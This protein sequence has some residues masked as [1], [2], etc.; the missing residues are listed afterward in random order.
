MQNNQNPLVSIV[1]PV[2]NGA[3]YMREAIDSALSQTYE[4]IEVLVV[5]DGS[6]DNGAT[7]KIALS[8]GSRIRYFYKENGGVS[9]A[10][11]LGIREMNGEFFSWLSHDDVYTLDK[12]EKEM[13]ALNSVNDKNTIINCGCTYIDK[14]SEVINLK[15][16]K[17]NIKSNVLFSWREVINIL[18]EEGAF[19]GCALLIPKT[20]LVLCGFFD[21]RMRFTQDVYM[22]YKIFFN[23]YS[24]YSI[25]TVCV[26]SRIHKKQVTQTGQALFHDDCELM[27]EYLIEQFSKNSTKE[28]KIIYKYVIDNAK[29]NNLKIVKKVYNTL[30][31]HNFSV[32]ERFNIF[33][34]SL[35]GKIRPLIRKIYY[36]VLLKTKTRG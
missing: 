27:S 14:N 35:Y 7:E 17:V 16:R 9:S 12:V 2:Y 3:N 23:G 26:K 22:W 15:K 4:N 10:L 29:N 1:I 19:N 28:D 18:I 25:D 11:N 36:K 6:T 31:K 33:I 24:L 20:A 21:E 13:A 8:Y 34:V 30:G 5:N 32:I